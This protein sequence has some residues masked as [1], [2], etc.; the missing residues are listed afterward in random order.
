MPI[1][2]SFFKRRILRKTIEKMVP[3]LVQGYGSRDFY[4]SGQV[5]QTARSVQA[6]KRYFHYNLALFCNQLDEDAQR[7]FNMTQ[8]E[9]EKLRLELA[10]K[11]FSCTEYTAM[12]VLSLGQSSSWKGGANDDNLSNHYGM[13]SRY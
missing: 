6:S 1:F 9:L 3:A 11:I 12:D 7:R 4:T 8:S 10:K 13:N 5:L 2:R